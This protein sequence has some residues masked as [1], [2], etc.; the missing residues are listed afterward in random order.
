MD[1]PYAEVIG[2]PIAH[3]K[4]P[5]I[6][7]FWLEKLG[8]QGDYRP[9]RI[10]AGEM[11]AYFAERRADPDWRGCNVTMPLKRAAMFVPD[12]VSQ[13]IQ[14]ARAANCLAWDHGRLFGFNTDISGFAAGL[15]PLLEPIVKSHGKA[16]LHLQADVVGAG[17]AARAVAVALEGHFPDIAP[18]FYN[19]THAKAEAL[20]GEFR[21]HPLNGFPLAELRGYPERQGIDGSDLVVTILINASPLGMNG[22]PPL[23]VALDSYGEHTIVCDLVYDPV[24]TPLITAARERGL[25]TMSGLD[26]LVAQAADAFPLFFGQ[27]APRQHDEELRALL[28]S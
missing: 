14:A 27:P 9:H 4:S 21:G 16:R 28:T 8:L 18:S 1:V 11:N 3:S 19:R 15:A 13:D 6:H 22:Y 10:D 23:P 5:L 12:F 17:G 2:D 7:K 26:M 25:S 20:S 24:E